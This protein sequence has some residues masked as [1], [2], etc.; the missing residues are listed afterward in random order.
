LPFT[1]YTSAAFSGV[2]DTNGNLIGNKGGDYNADGYNWDVPNT[3]SFGR[4][5]SGKGKNAY[6]TGLFAA[7]DFP[8]P[9]LGQQGSLGRNTYDQPGYNNLDFTFEK[10]FDVP[11]FFAEKMKI[12][13]KGEVFNLF[14]RSNLTGI[15]RICRAAPSGGLPINCLHAV[16]SYICAQASSGL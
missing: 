8:T 15:A 6:L 16:C 13:A 5:L 10:F 7:S 11:W 4:K 3:P 1:V 12:E 14:N 9:N 2:Y